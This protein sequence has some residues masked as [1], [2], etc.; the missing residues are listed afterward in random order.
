MLT[1]KEK[2]AITNRKLMTML[3][4]YWKDSYRGPA[5]ASDDL[6]K[7]AAERIR[8]LEAQVKYHEDVDRARYA[9]KRIGY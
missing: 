8:E 9:Q 4:T 5:I 7:L 2:R 3:R 1:A 6:T